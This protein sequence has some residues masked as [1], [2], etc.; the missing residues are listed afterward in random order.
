MLYSSIVCAF[1]NK[2]GAYVWKR[3][4]VKDFIQHANNWTDIYYTSIVPTDAKS[5]DI[6]KFYIWNPNK[7]TLDIKQIELKWLNY[8]Q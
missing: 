6:V 2:E 8:S 5:G 1:E 7:I 3:M 4:F